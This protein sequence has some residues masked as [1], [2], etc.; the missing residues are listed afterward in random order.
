[1]RCTTLV[2][3]LSL[4]VLGAS[5]ASASTVVAMSLE[6]MTDHAQSIFI[7]RV[8]GIRADWNAERTRIYTYVTLSVERYLKGGSGS[9]METIRLL[10]GQVGP[11]RAIVSGTPLFEVGEDVLLFVAGAGARIPTVLGLSL[12]KF[13]I[14][15]EA[16][17]E[18]ILKRDISSLMI[19]DYRTDSRKPGD[20]VTRYRLSDVESK[21]RALV[22]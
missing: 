8:A 16:G 12:G 6:Q 11:Y 5:Q 20:P 3:L 2:L 10:G 21:I 17:G 9:K 19:Q 22:P 13:T 18:R 15:S 1:M 4:A 14:V 7:G